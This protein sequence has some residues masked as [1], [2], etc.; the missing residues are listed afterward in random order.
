MSQKTTR[1]DGP[2]P[3]A[4]AFACSVS[5][6][7]LLDADRDVAHAELGPVLVG[8]GEKYRV[9]EWLRRE[10]EVRRDEREERRDRDEDRRARSH[11]QSP[12]RR[13]S[14]I[15]MSNAMQME[16]N[17]AAST[18]QSSNSQST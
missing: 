15:T 6:A 18:A 2:R 1:R 12:S 9:P 17:C 11:H 8:R 16:R 4:Y 14:P 13:A 10:V 5:G 3:K 7:D